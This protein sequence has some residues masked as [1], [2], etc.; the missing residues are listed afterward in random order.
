MESGDVPLCGVQSFNGLPLLP[1]LALDTPGF[2]MICRK[3]D[4][5]KKEVVLGFN[6]SVSSL[7]NV[8]L[9]KSHPFLYLLFFLP[10]PIQ[11]DLWRQCLPSGISDFSRSTHAYVCWLM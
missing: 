9:T 11:K 4:L 5:G 10:L 6:R 8:N 1:V 2:V 7:G 3:L